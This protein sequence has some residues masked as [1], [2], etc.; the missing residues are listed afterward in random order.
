MNRLMLRRGAAAGLATTSRPAVT[1]D[2]VH[3][4]AQEEWRGEVIEVSWSPRAFLFK[5]FLSESEAQHLIDKVRWCQQTGG[6]LPGGP[7]LM[8]QQQAALPTAC[9][10]WGMQP[11]VSG[12]CALR[13]GQLYGR[14][15]Y[16]TI[17]DQPMYF[18]G[19][20]ERESYMFRAA[21]SVVRAA[22]LQAKPNMVKST[23][24]DNDTGKSIDSTVRTST[25][26]FFGREVRVRLPF[27]PQD[28]AACAVSSAGRQES[29]RA[30]PTS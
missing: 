13:T 12:S 19:T 22:C 30:P 24:V 5:G 8:L 7:A 1:R 25:G 27:W 11:G 18:T 16:V 20:H 6:S 4:R 26:T 29:R 17:S 3:A 21:K 9:P 2:D 15:L 14:V 10:L 28:P 23:V